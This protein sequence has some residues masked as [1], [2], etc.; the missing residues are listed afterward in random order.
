[1]TNA[2]REAAERVQAYIDAY[3][4]A[5]SWGGHTMYPAAPSVAD[6]KAI[7]RHRETS[8]FGE[9]L[10]AGT[11]DPEPCPHCGGEAETYKS[12]DKVHPYRTVCKGCGASTSYHGDWFQCVAFW[13]RRAAPYDAVREALERLKGLELSEDGLSLR[14]PYDGDVDGDGRWITVGGNAVITFEDSDDGEAA[15]QFL[16]AALN[17][18]LAAER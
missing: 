2:D 10:Q 7:L 13:N 15:R 4:D 9:G 18:Q 3:E 17:N 5:P 16:L 12:S 1:M 8:T 6:L 11:L 14:W